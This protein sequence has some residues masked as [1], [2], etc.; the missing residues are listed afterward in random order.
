MG[1]VEEFAK[2]G[3][4][5]KASKVQVSVRIDTK[6]VDL[7]DMLASRM[8]MTRTGMASKLLELAVRDAADLVHPEPLNIN[9]KHKAM[10]MLS[11]S[12]REEER[13]IIADGE[14]SE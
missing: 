7:L 6:R 3:K 4:P 10:N 5:V 14:F 8:Q 12:L 13:E 9:T 2:Q 11:R 1:R